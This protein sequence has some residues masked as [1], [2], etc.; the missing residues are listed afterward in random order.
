[1]RENEGFNVIVHSHPFDYGEGGFSPTDE[2]HINSHFDCSLLYTS[3]K[4]VD[5]NR[6]LVRTKDYV[7]RL[8]NVKVFIVDEPIEGIEGLENIRR[9]TTS[10]DYEYYYGYDYD[11][12]LREKET[13]MKNK[14][15]SLGI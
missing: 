1:M 3:A 2:S 12:Y 7:I 14:R 11:D 13:K 5:I 9:V 8:E 10:C 4:K 6:L 15:F